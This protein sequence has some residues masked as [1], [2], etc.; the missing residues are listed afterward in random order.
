[1]AALKCVAATMCGLWQLFPPGRGTWSASSVIKSAS[2]SS[3]TPN[4]NVPIAAAS[5]CAISSM[6]PLPTSAPAASEMAA[7]DAADC[8]A[9]EDS[10]SSGS[11]SQ[12][13]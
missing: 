5:R 13:Y 10:S 3:R 6:A 1:M 7:E 2:V 8:A 4:G 9:V 12:V 11:A